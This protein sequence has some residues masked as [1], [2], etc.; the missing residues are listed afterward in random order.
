MLHGG[1][2]LYLPVTKAFL[3][4]PGEVGVFGLGDVGRVYLDGEASDRWHSGFGGGLY[5]V[6][7]NRNNRVELSYARSEG[8]NGFY[9]RLGLAL[10]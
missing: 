10:P 7:P 6:S 5:F 2:D 1:A 4:V 9:L 3:L 8:R